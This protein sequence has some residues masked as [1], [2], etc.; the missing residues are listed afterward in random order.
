[1]VSFFTPFF[2]L[3]AAFVFIFFTLISSLQVSAQ[4]AFT[5]D[6]QLKAETRKS[7]RE[8]ARI[9]ADY[10]ESHL[11]T[12]NFTYKK[13]KAGR[14]QVDIEEGWES[15]QFNATNDFNYLEP[16]KLKLKRKANRKKK[17]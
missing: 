12:S 11:N 7:R 9:E 1:M 15:Y 10:K 4:I 14:K 2:H 6:A 5:N 3:K 13:G 17:D 8:A 16:K